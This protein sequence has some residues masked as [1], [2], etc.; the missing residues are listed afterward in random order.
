MRS[1]SVVRPAFT[2]A[3]TIGAA[4]AS[5]LGQTYRELQLVVVDDGSSDAT[6]AI[7][8]AHGGSIRLVQQENGGVAAARNA[9]IAQAEGE[10]I[11]FCDA[12]DYLFPQHLE[13]LVKRWE[14]ESGIVTA[15]SYWLFPGGID[16]ARVRHKGAFPSPGRQRRAI[17]EQNFVSTMSVFPKR[18]ADE[19]G[20]FAADLHRAEDW[21]FWMR[22]IY[23]GHTVS[24]ERRPL[25]LY[26]WGA[27]GLSAATVEMDAAVREVL[28]RAERD[29]PL[30][31]EERA[32]VHERLAHDDLS[33][34]ARSADRALRDGRYREAARGFSEVARLCPAERPLVW[35]ARVL[36]V[37]PPLVGPLVRKRQL[38]IERHVGYEDEHA[39]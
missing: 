3:S 17:L 16:P 34:L 14:R 1:V 30:N 21:H 4:V 36:S 15:N 39:R 31:A 10:L 26:R 33:A 28:A 27:T 19:I 35:K 6:A 22:A 37:A 20:P 2:A 13:A 8:R 12:D 23:A 25:S 38:R 32:Y 7:V 11:A 5:V 18:L 24:L 29:L 9:G